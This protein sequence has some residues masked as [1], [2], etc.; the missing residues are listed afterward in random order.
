MTA[1]LRPEG[2][3]ST[4]DPLCPKRTPITWNRHAAIC[5]CDLIAEVRADERERAAQRV[6][7]CEPWSLRT[8]SAEDAVEAARRSW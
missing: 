2:R 6:S 5:H 4:H 3:E 1:N 7:A 8:I